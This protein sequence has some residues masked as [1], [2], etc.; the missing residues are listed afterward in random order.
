MPFIFDAILILIIDADIFIAD[1]SPI[2][3]SF[4]FFR[5]FSL[6]AG[7]TFSISLID[8]FLLSSFFASIFSAAS[9]AMSFI[10]E[11]HYLLII[12]YYIIPVIIAV[13]PADAII[14]D[15]DIDKRLLIAAISIIIADSCWLFASLSLSFALIFILLL[16]RLIALFIDGQR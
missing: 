8:L 14:A 11:C 10:S 12:I 6:I 16:I 2:F 1:I 9:M 7:A 3:S 5:H 15:A 13:V 4:D